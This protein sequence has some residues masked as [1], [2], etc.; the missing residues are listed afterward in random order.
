[1]Y[2]IDVLIICIFYIYFRKLQNK[3]G[4][5]YKNKI[6]LKTKIKLTLEPKRDHDDAL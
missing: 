3:I 2:G 4:Y 1:M 6:K 5:S